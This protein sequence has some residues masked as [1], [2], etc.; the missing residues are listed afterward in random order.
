[1]RVRCGRC[2]TVFEVGGSGRHRCPTCHVTNEVRT[3]V[4]DRDGV[5]AGDGG[6]SRHTDG[7]S[8]SR[9]VRSVGVL[10]G[11]LVSRATNEIARSGRRALWY[12]LSP[13]RGLRLS[14]WTRVLLVVFGAVALL[15][16]GIVVGS[17][18]T[19]E[20][21]ATQIG[22]PAAAD[23]ASSASAAP[24]Q[25][26][27]TTTHPPTTTAVTTTTHPPVTTTAAPAANT[28]RP[29]ATTAVQTT[30]S[31]RQVFGGLAGVEFAIEGSASV[32][33]G[34]LEFTV[35]GIEKFGQTIHIEGYEH[36][37]ESSWL[38]VT[39]R[40][41]NVTDRVLTYKSKDQTL[42]SDGVT[43]R[44]ESNMV[45]VDD[46]QWV[47]D[48]SIE[49]IPLFFDVPEAFPEDQA[50]LLLNLV[51]NDSDTPPGVV[52]VRVA[53]QATEEAPTVTSNT[54]TAAPAAT[55]TQP[56]PT[57]DP[58]P[59]TTTIPEYFTE[60]ELVFINAAYQALG[61]VDERGELTNELAHADPELADAARRA[62]NV[63]WDYC[64]AAWVEA[65]DL[66]PD[67]YAEGWS[68]PEAMAAGW[69]KVFVDYELVWN[70]RTELVAVAAA[71][72][73][74]PEGDPDDWDGYRTRSRG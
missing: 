49:S 3:A 6:S 18:M 35:L 27:T 74:C 40:V 32:F 23:L 12:V 53:R 25:R 33:N 70:E 46:S 30:T 48:S 9:R 19:G 10:L 69:E 61:A 29:T 24:T 62:I 38:V 8:S 20:E 50:L 72:F 59:A 43:Y 34:G 58:V 54:T 5:T 71:V 44:V 55:T 57:T 31:R 65:S 42:F 11:V 26:L 66:V 45:G 7:G 13:I 60:T 64:L 68:T 63:W 14:H 16:A 52:H 41:E 15:A 56:P 21:P 37:A 2:G 73:L 36:T 22:Q 67:P 4:D 39:L 47:G 1:M 17:R 51:E 28:T